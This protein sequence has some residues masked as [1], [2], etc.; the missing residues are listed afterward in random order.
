MT[1][2]CKVLPTKQITFEYCRFDNW[3]QF[4]L[5]KH[6]FCIN[7]IYIKKL[8]QKNNNNYF[9]TSNIL[10]TM[11]LQIRKLFSKYSSVNK[12]FISMGAQTSPCQTVSSS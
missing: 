5:K 6:T 3:Y 2:D 11:Q 1:P 7:F 8:K 4:I 9:I 10:M 12:C